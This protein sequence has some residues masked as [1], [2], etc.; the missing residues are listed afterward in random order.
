MRYNLSHGFTW[1]ISPLEFKGNFKPQLINLNIDGNFESY[2]V[3]KE[4]IKHLRIKIL[5]KIL[6]G[7]RWQGTVQYHLLLS[8]G[9]GFP[10]F[11][12]D[13]EF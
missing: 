3:T 12:K 8:K 1:K 9:V 7:R 11:D 6:R 5:S 10:D 4:M 2:T 13:T